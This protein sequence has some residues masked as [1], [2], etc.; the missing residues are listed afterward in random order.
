MKYQT[1]QHPAMENLLILHFDVE[2]SK[3]LVEEIRRSDNGT[4]SKK[5]L[6]GYLRNLLKRKDVYFYI[7]YESDYNKLG[8][9]K[10][11]DAKWE[12]ILY[13][14]LTEIYMDVAS[15]SAN[16]FD[17][18]IEETGNLKF[19]PIEQDRGKRWKFNTITKAKNGDEDSRPS[20]EPS[21]EDIEYKNMLADWFEEGKTQYSA[22]HMLIVDDRTKDDFFPVYITADE[23]PL[24]IYLEWE[25]DIDTE[26]FE[27]YWLDQDF[28]R[29]YN[30]NHNGD[31]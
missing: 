22:T 26:V 11:K 19:M 31:A 27:V 7:V 29:Q 4:Y 17:I 9:G 12:N 23:D 2:I 14:I 21:F 10:H 28:E 16:S 1:E 25:D 8:I 30:Y 13:P 15:E 18:D 20:D 6:P 24:E 3:S 5:A